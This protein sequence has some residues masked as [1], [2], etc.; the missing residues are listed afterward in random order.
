MENVQLVQGIKIENAGRVLYSQENNVIKIAVPANESG[1][2][3]INSEEGMEL[4]ISVEKAASLDFII[5]SNCKEIKEVKC[6]IILEED[7]KLKMKELHLGNVSIKNT[8]T[9]KKGSIVTRQFTNISS[10]KVN[11]ILDCFLVGEGADFSD[12]EVHFGAKKGASENRINVDHKASNTK[13]LIRVKGACKDASKN[14]IL[15]MVRVDKNTENANTFL[16][17]HMLM[18]DKDA[19]ASAIPALEIESAEVQA[20]H[21]ASVSTIDEDQ[22]FYVSTRGIT[23]DEAKKEIVKGFLVDLVCEQKIGELIEAAW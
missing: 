14:K 8:L 20:G 9:C 18:L 12:E 1:K 6:E 11:V 7:A 3:K 15:G 17:A 21:A 2:V 13:S 10:G 19:E 5:E 23:E 22:L 4:K 16:S